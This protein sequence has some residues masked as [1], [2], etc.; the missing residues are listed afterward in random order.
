MRQGVAGHGEQR[1]GDAAGSVAA[2][3]GEVVDG[4]RCDR[5]R[6]GDGPVGAALLPQLVEVIAHGARS[7]VGVSGADGGWIWLGGHLAS[8]SWSGCASRVLRAESK[9]RVIS[10]SV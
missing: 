5:G 10:G 7:R 9:V 8:A 3:D 2:T 4:R 6:G 1:R